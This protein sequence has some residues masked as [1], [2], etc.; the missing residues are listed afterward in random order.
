MNLLAAFLSGL[1][2][3]GGLV[4]SGMT[5]PKKVLGFL[6]PLGHFDP[7]LAFVMV[8]AIAVYALADRVRRAR[9]APLF[10]P[11]FVVPSNRSIDARLF[12]GALIFGVG[13]GLAGYCPGPSL[14][15]L[16]GGGVTKLLFVLAMATGMFL[17]DVLS[18]RR[19]AS[20]PSAAKARPDEP[21]EVV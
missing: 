10:G 6:D 5:Q 2:F 9:A 18:R 12:S 14:V 19:A 20:P 8:G 16:A 11:R 3:G 1:L 7:S 17:T 15:A 13:W 21:A 4:I